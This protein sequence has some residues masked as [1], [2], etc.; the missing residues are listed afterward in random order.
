MECQHPECKATI[1]LPLDKEINVK[2]LGACP[3]CQRPWLTNSGNTLVLSV[4]SAIDRIKDLKAQMASGQWGVS[5]TLE[6]TNDPP[7]SSRTT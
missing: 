2:R 6:V 1:F 7:N 4:E 5:I 3:I